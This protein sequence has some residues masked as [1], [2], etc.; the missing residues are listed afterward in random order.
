[1]NLVAVSAA[2][3]SA[4]QEGEVLGDVS[5][6]HPARILRLL[7]SSQGSSGP[8]SVTVSARCTIPVPG[9]GQVCSEE[10]VVRAERSDSL[11]SIVSS[12][13]VADVPTIV[14]WHLPVDPEDPLLVPLATVAD[15]VLV[16]STAA[17]NPL[18]MLRLW[19]EL[20]FSA[21]AS[22]GGIQGV[23]LAG[24]LSWT[25]L[26]PWRSMLAAAVQ[27]PE[28]RPLLGAAVSLQIDYTPGALAQAVLFGAWVAS[29]LG[30]SLRS[31]ELSDRGGEI[32]C[33]AGGSSA[34]LLIRLLPSGV[35]GQEGLTRTV[36]TGGEGRR[37]ELCQA[38]TSR[39]ARVTRV[40]DGVSTDELVRHAG[41][42][43]EAELLV[44]EL[45]L[46]EHDEPYESA[47]HW[48]ST[49]LERGGR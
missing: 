22:D 14:L 29:R 24:D 25:R 9:R 45:E 23:T 12:L 5:V 6:A 46:L 39:C 15:R 16:D 38:E 3:D 36:L 13:L 34:A 27:S 47:M 35:E 44:R 33:A 31:A 7:V 20:M 26:A 18:L 10:I 30:W 8:V 11:F 21:R 49:V 28:M 37:V 19:H 17:P 41:A 48:A 43:S 32:T 42:G 2:S 1:M 4:G 40:H